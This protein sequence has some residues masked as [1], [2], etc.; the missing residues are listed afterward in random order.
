M[1]RLGVSLA[2]FILVSTVACAQHASGPKRSRARV[3]PSRTLVD[4]RCGG[5][6]RSAFRQTSAAAL[7]II[8]TNCLRRVGP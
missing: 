1:L 7:L 5:F 8:K 2:A 6:V 3:T 4:K